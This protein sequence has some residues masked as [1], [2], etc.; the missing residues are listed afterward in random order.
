MS[1]SLLK[2]LRR[3]AA[4]MTGRIAQKGY[5]NLRSSSAS[6]LAPGE[7]LPRSLSGKP[8]RVSDWS[9]EEAIRRGF[10][11][12]VNIY[13]GIDA[14]AKAVSS[15]PIV[16]ST[17]PN[18]HG[19]WQVAD[20][21]ALLELLRR[22]NQH[23]S[24]RKWMRLLVYALYIAGNALAQKVILNRS[25]R[26]AKAPTIGALLPLVPVGWSPIPLADED[27]LRGYLYQRGGVKREFATGEI[28]HLMFDDPSNPFWGMSPL[29]PAQGVTETMRAALD[30]NRVAMDNRTISDL[31]VISK[32]PL[33][34]EEYD[35]ARTK[36]RDQHQGTGAAREPWL[37]GNDFDIRELGSTPVEMD[38]TASLREYRKD[39]LSALGVPPV[40]AGYFDDATL[41]N[42]EVSVGMFWRETVVPLCELISDGLRHSLIPHFGDANLISIDFDFDRVP[43]LQADLE[44]RMRVFVGFLRAGVPYN[45]AIALVDLDLETVPGVGDLPFGV[46]AEAARAAFSGEGGTADEPETEL[47]PVVQAP[48]VEVSEQSVLNGAQIAAATAIVESVADGTIPRDSGRGQLIVLFN[49][50]EEQ[51]EAILGSAGTG[52]ATNPNVNPAASVEPAVAATEGAGGAKALL[53]IEARKADGLS[54]EVDTDNANLVREMNRLSREFRIKLLA[55]I[56]SALSDDGVA[57][58]VA[59]L[60]FGNPAQIAAKLGLVDLERSLIPLLR[61][62]MLTALGSG[63]Q[64]AA[65]ALARV[66][67]E[68]AADAARM[69]LQANVYAERMTRLLMDTSRRGIDLLVDA[70]RSGSYGSASATDLARVLRGS[71]G[72]NANHYRALDVAWRGAVQAGSEGGDKDLISQLLQYARE[73]SAKRID[74]V[75]DNE[76]VRALHEGQ[77]TAWRQ[78]K[79]EGKVESV[80]KTWVD[81]DDD[82]VCSTCSGLDGQTVDIDEPFVHDGT[83]Y[84]APPGPHPW[85]RCG[86]LL[87]IVSAD[88]PASESLEEVA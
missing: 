24:G 60:D 58:L 69:A 88:V 70:Y 3:A 20:S 14:I 75:A 74:G 62:L 21:H 59:M 17:R 22:P 30:W 63:G 38:F 65:R 1:F 25:E 16:V 57:A 37:L 81:N 33:L 83:E 53:R 36:I 80:R 28:L 12:N 39:T 48:E 61:E 79:A 49:L 87:E 51:A 84:Q 41:A 11:A 44:K 34:G 7:L 52:A 2:G 82:I 4:A 23:M 73:A 31:A 9:A 29:E 50:S 68:F 71:F 45:E 26:G 32:V 67:I 19:D 8:L 72:A 40:L 10:K 46:S 66:G 85:C 27:F 47:K 18:V 35:E 43:A 77:L 13:R 76:A 86:T 64:H 5:N 78:A 42:A 15:V 56:R 6:I 54:F 55:A